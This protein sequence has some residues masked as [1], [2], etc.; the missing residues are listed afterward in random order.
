M[1]EQLLWACLLAFQH[2]LSADLDRR[3]L[4]LLLSHYQQ[5]PLFAASEHVAITACLCSRLQFRAKN[6]QRMVFELLPTI[7]LSSSLHT[8]SD[9]VFVRQVAKHLKPNSPFT[10][11]NAPAFFC[12]CVPLQQC[13]RWWLVGYCCALGCLSLFVV[14]IR[15]NWRQSA[16]RRH[17]QTFRRM[18]RPMISWWP[19]SM[20]YAPTAPNL[21]L[22]LIS[23]LCHVW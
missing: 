11:S 12:C 19:S 13:C 20:L 17:R 9:D 2:S 10:V 1:G 16:C 8:V 4:T 18:R 23:L 21:C 14:R 5:Y 3:L 15:C 22:K 6:V 7:L